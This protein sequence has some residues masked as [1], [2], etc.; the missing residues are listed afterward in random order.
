[1]HTVLN[2]DR[3]GLFFLARVDLGPSSRMRKTYPRRFGTQDR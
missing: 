1:M 2:T 3:Q